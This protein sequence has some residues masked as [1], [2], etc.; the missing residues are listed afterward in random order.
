MRGDGIAVLILG[1]H[2][3]LVATIRRISK[4]CAK[5]GVA[6]PHDKL[7]ILRIGNL[8]LI[9]PKTFYGDITA[10]SLLSPQ[11]VHAVQTHLQE[12]T[13]DPY[14]TIWCGLIESTAANAHDLSSTTGGGCRLGAETACQRKYH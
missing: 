2:V 11:T 6:H 4:T 3:G 5:D 14:H 7:L 13:V 1:N 8:R 10:R 9:H 12:P